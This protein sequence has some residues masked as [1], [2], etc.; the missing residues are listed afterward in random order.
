M[1]QLRANDAAV[2]PDEDRIELPASWTGALLPQRGKRPGREVRLDREAPRTVRELIRR[3]KEELLDALARPENRHYVAASEAYIEG[4]ADAR[5][6]G[7]V[8]TLLLHSGSARASVALRPGLDAWVLDHGLPFA[9][10]ASIERFAVGTRWDGADKWDRTLK[11]RILEPTGVYA[12]HPVIQELSKGIVLL[13]S[14]LADTSDEEYAAVVEAAAAHRD[15]PVKRL[16]AMLLLPTERAWGDQACLDYATGPA[17]WYGDRVMFHAVQSAEQAAAAEMTRIDHYQ[18]TSGSLAPLVDNLGS[19]SLP[20]LTETLGRSSLNAGERRL[21]LSAVAMLPSDQ[22]VEYL[23]DHLAEPH[24]FSAAAE[25]AARFPVRTLR[26]IARMADGAD[27]GNR[28]KL[29]GLA[30]ANPTAVTAAARTVLTGDERAAIDGLLTG[31]DTVEDAASEDLPALLV[32]PPW[33][34]R[35]AERKSAVIAGLEPPAAHRMVWAEGEQQRWASLRDDCYSGFNDRDWQHFVQDPNAPNWGHRLGAVLA[36]G[37]EALAEEH[38][39]RWEPPLCSESA[40]RLQAMLG[41]FGTRVSHRVVAYLRDH[42][43]HHEALVPIL[44]PEAARLAADWLLRVKSA[45]AS[46]M[47]WIDRHGTEGARLLVPDALGAAKKPR[48]SAESA[49]AFLAA[50]HGPSAVLAAA[51]PYGEAARD[52]V[53]AL[54]SADPLAPP[55]GMKVPKPALWASPTILPQVLLKGRKRALPSESVGHLTTVLALATP[56]FPYAGIDV[57][58]ETC[59]RDSLCDFSWALFEQWLATGAPPKDGWALTQLVHFADEETVR[60][61]TP[62]IRQWPGQSQHKRAVAGLEALGAIGSE[63]ALRAIHGIAQKVKFKALK[64]RAAEQIESI[65]AGLGLTAEQLAD[66]LVPDFGLDDASSLVLDYGPRRF[67]VGFDE[68]L[69]PFVT[70]EDGKP[71]K[72]L[73]KPGAKDDA[74]IAGAAY[75]RFSQLK[76]DLRTVA[77]EQVRRLE[78]AMVTGRTWTA[79]EFQEHFVDHPLVWHLARRLVWLAESDGA[80]TA[81][82]LAEDKSCTDVEEDEFGLPGDAV[83]RLAHPAH[84][85]GEALEAWAEILADYEILQPFE[86]LSRP[87]MAFTE[88]ELQTGRLE[89][90][91]GIEVDV[92]RILG[93][94]NR[95][96]HRAMPEDAGIEPGIAYP[97]P[98]GGFVLVGLNPGIAVGAVDETPRQRLESVRISADD[99]YWYG[100]RERRRDHPTDIDAVTSS[101]IVAALARVTKAN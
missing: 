58:A 49:L 96:W 89:R 39:D 15:S 4:G 1:E 100:G 45:R 18:I 47:A 88:E 22:A 43:A 54:L 73:P 56:E 87:V 59:D 79:G 91:E 62:L 9:V 10:C 36:Y 30:N 74:A 57:L 75:K 27:A 61:L 97:L 51:E 8:S 14:L 77:A 85:D 17:Y 66:R 52:A 86:Q 78:R 31:L 93:M 98:N 20:I 25:A 92:G 99:Y 16:I 70:D 3:H 23:L 83:I 37:P 7:A 101:E 50:R 38:L 69:K 82:R 34:R 72:S 32:D 53:E 21:L 84:L 26:A 44:T 40:R 68:Q 71:R 24:V 5:G 12:L 33:R 48:R 46:A 76:K 65:A 80:T 6:A 60:R 95:G 81:F 2:L 28:R 55:Q 94:V 63:A 41:R 64:K 29:A 13:R 35:R 67:K 11:S 90:F 42:S 19:Q